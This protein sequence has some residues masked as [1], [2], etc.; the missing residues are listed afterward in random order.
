LRASQITALTHR[1]FAALMN[2]ATHPVYL[3]KL[4]A[5]P[6][7]LAKH[8]DL[9]WDAPMMTVFRSVLMRPEQLEYVPVL[10][11]RVLDEISRA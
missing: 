7:L 5:K 11:E 4:I 9:I 2:D 3:A 6:N 10:H 8:S 1:V